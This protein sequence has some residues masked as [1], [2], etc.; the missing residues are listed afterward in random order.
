MFSLSIITFLNN[1]EKQDFSCK[2]DSHD[3]HLTTNISQN[4][5]NLTIKKG[6]S[7]R[8]LRGYGISPIFFWWIGLNLSIFVR[9]LVDVC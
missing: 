4:V 7:L 9:S 3:N 8:N 2:D 5:K 6:K 1:L